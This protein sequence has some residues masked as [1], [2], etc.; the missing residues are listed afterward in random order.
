[1]QSLKIPMEGLGAA[2]GL[3]GTA[4]L[5]AHPAQGAVTRRGVCGRYY[6]ALKFPLAD[7]SRLIRGLKQRRTWR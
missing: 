5:C 7:G 6:P 1:M 2:Q 4:G 3:D